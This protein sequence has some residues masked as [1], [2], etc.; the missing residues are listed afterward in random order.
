MSGRFVPGGRSAQAAAAACA[1][2]AAVAILDYAE[3]AGLV[4][5]RGFF[6]GLALI[7]FLG[8]MLL[9]SWWAVL[10]LPVAAY[11]GGWL[12][13]ELWCITAHPPCAPASATPLV[14]YVVYGLRAL[15]LVVLFAAVGAL[16]SRPRRRRCA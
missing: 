5:P 15:G 4:G 11:A 10:V 9:R 6:L 13:T 7:S 3:L 2:I 16:L 12:G 1:T 14:D 8:G